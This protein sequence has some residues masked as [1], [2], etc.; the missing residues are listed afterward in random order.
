MLS[1]SSST[2]DSSPSS[3]CTLPRNTTNS[4]SESPCAYCSSP[5]EPPGSS[6]PAKTSRCRSGRGVSSIFRPR[7]PK[8]SVCRSARRST[9]VRGGPS[10]WKRSEIEM[11]SPSAIRR[12]D[13]M[14]ALARPRSTWLRKLSLRPARSATSRSVHRRAVRISRRRSPTSISAVVSGAL[15]GIGQVLL[16]FDPVEEEL[17]RRYGTAEAKVK[18]SDHEGLGSQ[19][20]LGEAVGGE[21]REVECRLAA[22][23]QLGEVFAD[24]GRLLE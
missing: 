4:S 16:A 21:G 15:D 23:D 10:G 19:C 13:A 2:C 20:A 14:L 12:S 24:R 9:L 5:V 7:T 1:P 8:A 3:S 11:P 22:D 18:P 17:K 6:S